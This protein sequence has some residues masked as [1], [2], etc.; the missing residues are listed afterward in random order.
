MTN[1]RLKNASY[2]L[3]VSP[4]VVLYA[5]VIIFPVLVS[6]V[7]GFFKWNGFD[8]PVFTGLANYFQMFNDPQFWHDIRNNLLIVAVSMF[9][10]IPLG[11][12][13]AY[14]LY[15]RIVKGGPFFETMIFL[16]ITISAIIVAILWNRMF[17]PTGVLV[18][19]MRAITGNPRWIFMIQES[20]AWSIV[21]I[22]FV[23]LWMY[24]GLY[25]IIFLANMQ[26]IQQST[27]EAAL[28]DGAT[29]GQI[30]SRVIFP[31]M[32][33]V[34][35]TCSVF[36]ISGSL[37]SFDLIFAMTAGGPARYTEVVSIYM[38]ENTFH[39]SINPFGM[40]AASSMMIILLSVLLIR[41]TQKVFGRLERRY[42]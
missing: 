27:I 13:L 24:T 33:G 16:P 36:A 26:K 39:Y 15:R 28:L 6:F 25:M 14:V 29:E 32:V 38:Y 18:H 21:P 3:L 4:A 40:G 20:R 22:L 31:N 11:F 19:I 9:G 37:K 41:I 23:I 34:I 5:A 8:T 30:L 2:A 10:Q 12:I 7:V 35:F 17:S 1:K 42:S